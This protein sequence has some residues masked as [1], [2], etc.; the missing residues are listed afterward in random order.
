MDEK[1]FNR[2]EKKYLITK[3]QQDALRDLIR[4]HLREDL[5]FHSEI[6]NIYFDTDNYD[7]IIQ[8]I[9]H[10]VFKQKVRA[11]SYGGYDKVF[12]EIK[13]KLR[14]FAYRHDLL[15]DEDAA[16]DDN[17][18]HKRRV[19]VTRADFERFLSGAATT[20]E[21]ALQVTEYG[22]VAQIAREIDY[23]MQHFGLKPK[24]LLYYDRESYVGDDGLRITFDTNMRYR[25]K[26][27]TFLKKPRDKILLNADNSIIMEIKACSGMPLWLVK[28]LSA[29]HLYPVQFSKIGKAY[30][31]LRKENYV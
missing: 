6:Y 26:N 28:H 5:Y 14:G 13:T 10:P 29:E 17:Q 12:L 9:D 21:L 7:L 23:A 8:S 25:A 15:E 31:L 4:N 19:L 11:R 22:T 16:K 27:L 24:I 2:V 20:E 3:S 30:E 18:G 1:I